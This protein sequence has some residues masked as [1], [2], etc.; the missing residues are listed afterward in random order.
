M[1]STVYVRASVSNWAVQGR[2]AAANARQE[3]HAWLLCNLDM[4]LYDLDIGETTSA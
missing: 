4:A 2:E 3:Q 1:V